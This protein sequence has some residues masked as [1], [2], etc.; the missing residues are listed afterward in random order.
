MTI[1]QSITGKWQVSGKIGI[2][3]QLVK[4]R[5]GITGSYEAGSRLDKDGKMVGDKEFDS[6]FSL[7]HNYPDI[8]W[9]NIWDN[10]REFPEKVALNVPYYLLLLAIIGCFRKPVY[11][12]TPGRM[13]LYCTFLP[14]A[15]Y[16]IFSFDPRYFYPYVPILLLFSVSGADWLSGC[17][18]RRFLRKEMPIGIAL[19]AI[20][21]AYYFYLDIPRVPSAPYD[22][23]QDGGRFDDKQVGLRL[24]K[25]L[26]SDSVLMTRSG[27]VAFYAN[28]PY[29]IP[30]D[31]DLD[32]SLNY[33][34]NNKITHII[35]N[36]QMYAMRPA[37]AALYTPLTSPGFI[38]SFQG[39]ELVYTGQEPGGQP[40]LVYK[41]R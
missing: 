28:M 41:L 23:T 17:L 21:S 27:R 18:T 9:K 20:L 1:L 14:L 22:Y 3:M 5:Y 2:G 26:P 40:Y 24:K 12:I 32:A 30:P 36:M 19:I 7:L 35:A 34:R 38:P 8:F 16:L 37:F 25:I 31:S 39:L 4:E 15:S 13:P 33:A 6:I 29:S 11:A 10:L